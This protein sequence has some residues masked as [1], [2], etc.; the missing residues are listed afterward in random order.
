MPKDYTQYVDPERVSPGEGRA[1]ATR[2]S[3]RRTSAKGSVDASVPRDALGTSLGETASPA[4]AKPVEAP[5]ARVPSITNEQVGAGLR[6][7]GQDLYTGLLDDP[8][9]FGG[10]DMSR[11]P[12][13]RAIQ[14][15]GVAAARRRGDAPTDSDMSLPQQSHSHY[16]S[17]DRGMQ[18]HYDDLEA[19]GKP[20]GSHALLDRMI[21]QTEKGVT[22]DFQR[23]LI[24]KLRT[25]V[26]DVK[27]HF[28]DAAINSKGK[29][30][31][32]NYQHA[33]GKITV[34]TNHTHQTHTVLHELVHAGTVKFIVDNPTHPLTQELNRLY[35][36]TKTRIEEAKLDLKKHGVT[37]IAADPYGMKDTFEFVAEAMTNKKFQEFLAKSERYSKE[38]D[39]LRT[40]YDKFVDVV[41][42]IFG[43]DKPETSALLNNVLD[44]SNRIIDKQ[45]G[46]EVFGAQAEAA[47]SARIEGAF[48]RTRDNP[49]IKV[50]TGKLAAYYD[51]I[52]QT[53]NPE[54]RGS[55]GKDAGA[56]IASNIAK[57]MQHDTMMTNRAKD[58]LEFWDKRPK[59]AEQFI[60]GFEKGQ[61]FVDKTLQKVSDF[62]TE[63]NKTILAQDQRNGIKYEVQDHYLSHVF[64][65]EKGVQDYLTRR[66]GAKWTEPGFAKDRSFDLYEEAER[67]GFKPKFKN[68]EDIMLARQHSS[69]VAEAKVNILKDLERYG[70]AV[71][72][73]AGGKAP[74]DW[75]KPASRPSPNGDSYWIHNSAEG[76]LHNVYDSASMWNMKGIRGDAF[77]TMM[78]VKN[79]MVPVKLAFSLFHPLHV[80]T[81]DNVTG[82]VR[83]S[84]EMLSGKTGAVEG[85]G[86]ILKAGSY[87]GTL[88]ETAG[89]LPFVDI[90]G[91]GNRLLRMMQGKIPDSA[92][93]SADKT[94]MQYM[95]DGGFIPSISS[96]Y[97]LGAI[98]N[99]QRA[100][101]Q[102]RV[103][104]IWHLPGAMI[105]GLGKPIFEHWI[106]SLKTAS[107][108][109]DVKTALKTD[110]S[111]ID[112]A[113]KRQ[114]AFRKIAKSVDNRYG[115][116]QYGTLFWNRAVKDIGVLNT[117]SMGWQLGFIRE[118]G[119]GMLDAGQAL[120]PRTG[121]LAQKAATGKLDRPLFATLYTTQALMYGGL[122]TYWM[123]GQIP[124]SWEDYVYPR[125]GE[126]DDKGKPTRSSTFF[127]TREFGSIYKH[128][129]IDGP[130][131]AVGD[132]VTSK[133]SGIIG[134][135]TQAI[136]GVNNFGQQIRDPNGRAFTQIEQTV[137]AALSDAEPISLSQLE[138]GSTPLKGDWWQKQFGTK[139]GVLAKVGLSKAPKYVSESV[140]EG[141]IDSIY[142]R[143]YAPPTDCF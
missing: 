51:E 131:A 62:Y 114:V 88:K 47:S 142:N 133:A 41:K 17:I 68:P 79:S 90:G 4:E 102:R 72:K 25:R 89:S 39:N 44:V 82:V 27:I 49:A 31:A 139:E 30:V 108:M 60:K 63:W 140:T 7:A 57:Q 37:K 83:A 55:R 3:P 75:I 8:Y 52:L 109:A 84:K 43:I 120:N 6:V 113:L 20:T 34:G 64:E 130:L 77:K 117:L 22:G 110:P 46:H 69:N 129:Q 115:E 67:A 61:K 29:V 21:E 96:Q 127:Y 93:T 59:V 40:I 122:M 54:G 18:M 9:K 15:E 33:S 125:T 92:L 26:G 137:A 134:L 143:E 11:P 103:G 123:T 106:P 5:P 58:R 98:E 16:E 50:A 128:A 19:E 105:Q 126:T 66:Y 2:R 48:S 119:G 74:E 124:Q 141:K 135:A 132:V 38:G 28:V 45:A 10:V 138:T 97:K 91:S 136:T 100:L 12:E 81:I 86:Q 112:D 99:L 14:R 13:I 35:E 85:F 32:G 118:Y 107:Y 42:K 78:W 56:V 94:A 116:M 95:N 71:K 73:T 24:K 104:A 121:S 76:I 65:D 101:N 80:A 53:F 70:L 23:E 111:L 87:Y 36:L 1:S